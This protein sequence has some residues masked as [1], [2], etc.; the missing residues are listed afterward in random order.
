MQ[1]GADAASPSKGAMPQIP[2]IIA[3]S[4]KTIRPELVRLGKIGFIEVY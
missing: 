3:P 2:G 1:A 4:D